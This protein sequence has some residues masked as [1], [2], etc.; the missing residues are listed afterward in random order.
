[1]ANTTFD[2]YRLLVCLP[3]ALLLVNSHVLLSTEC[4]WE[5]IV[6]L[7]LGTENRASE[8]SGI[9]MVRRAFSHP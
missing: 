4:C 7:S 8:V 9:R 3:S 2:A 6:A 1:M 5:P